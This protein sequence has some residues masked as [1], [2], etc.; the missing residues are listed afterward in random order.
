M[1]KHIPVGHILFLGKDSPH[2]EEK[3]PNKKR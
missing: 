3:Q 2:E 1:K